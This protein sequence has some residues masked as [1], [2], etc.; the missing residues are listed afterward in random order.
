MDR[1]LVVKPQ[2]L[3]CFTISILIFW[4]LAW[5][6]QFQSAQNGKTELLRGRSE[7]LSIVGEYTIDNENWLPL[8]TEEDFKG[9]IGVRDVVIRANFTRNLEPDEAI[10]LWIDNLR[11]SVSMNGM[12]IAEFGEPGTYASFSRGPGKTYIAVNPLLTPTTNDVFRLEIH[13]PYPKAKERAIYN[14]V[15]GM[16]IVGE[17]NTLYYQV[18]EGGWELT[19]L[20]VAFIIISMYEFAAMLIYLKDRIKGDLDRIHQTTVRG[21][22]AIFAFAC[23]YYLMMDSLYETGP[24]L[25]S[26]PIMC[27]TLDASADFILCIALCVSYAGVL[28]VPILQ[29]I[30]WPTVTAISLVMLGCYIMQIFGIRDLYEVETVPMALILIL[31]IIAI[32]AMLYEYHVTK[33][34]DAKFVLIT[35]SP[36]VF[37]SVVDAVN[38]LV[39][40][41]NMGTHVTKV[42]LIITALLQF[43][44]LIVLSITASKR[45]SELQQTKAELGETRI[46]MTISQIQP[47]FLYNAL[48]TIQYL[49]STDPDKA[50]ITV[51]KFSKYLRGNMD[52]LSQKEP[53]PFDKE[54]EHL[55]N[56]L[57]IERLRF[58]DISYVYKFDVTDFLIPALTIQPLVENSIKY[59][60]RGLEDGGIITITTWEDEKSYFITVEDNGIGFDLNQK[61]DDGRSHVGMANIKSRVA[62]MVHGTVTIES[63]IGEGT[64]TTIEIPKEGNK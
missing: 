36:I 12:K 35:F 30:I 21:T 22:F 56:Y 29:K 31:T 33:R 54:I 37:F 58:P 34:S 26:N 63:A 45:Q 53:I 57:A 24:L 13:N 47:H 64:H 44:R 17:F 6:I 19:A 7:N 4:V 25:I 16:F 61:K 59:G 62:S 60:V 20:A 23:G 40:D 38:Y 1:K 48:N 51:E 3:I 18:F 5:V 42:G 43:I 14:G 32:P 28:T 50:A 11:V 10:T 27:N 55:E 39:L 46:A 49:C 41:G 8:E 15:K 2:L 52:S 9:L